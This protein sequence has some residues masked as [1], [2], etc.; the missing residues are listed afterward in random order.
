V[1]RQFSIVSFLLAL[2]LVLTSCD[3]S[4]SRTGYARLKLAEFTES[5]VN[6]SIILEC[7]DEGE[8]VLLATF[9][10]TEEDAHLYSM[11]LPKEGIDG[12]GRPTLIELPPGA[13]MQPAGDLQ[14]SVASYIDEV[15]PDLP[16]LP[17]YPVGAVTLSLPV[18][19]PEMDAEWVSDKVIITYMAC[20]STGCYKPVISKLVEVQVPTR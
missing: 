20:T 10:P 16:A 6:V 19:L 1:N 17:L 9:T 13:S 18:M 8:A 5:Y 12:L 3:L 4:A 15:T 7:V 11:E 2:A 14:E